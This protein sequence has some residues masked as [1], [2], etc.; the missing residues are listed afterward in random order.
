MINLNDLSKQMENDLNQRPFSTSDL[1]M[2]AEYFP[3]VDFKFRIILDTAEYQPPERDGNK[4]TIY[5]NGIMSIISSETEGINI[6]PL[7]YNALINTSVD[8]LIPMAQ[9]EDEDGASVLVEAVR[10]HIGTALQYGVSRDIEDEGG[11]KY[12]LGEFH[13]IGNT[14]MRAVRERVGDSMT[15]SLF[16]KYILIAAGVAS[17]EYQLYVVDPNDEEEPIVYSSLSLSRKTVIDYALAAEDANEGQTSARG[18][19]QNTVL[20][21][22]FSAPVRSANIDRLLADYMLRGTIEPIKIRL[23]IPNTNFPEGVILKMV[24]ESNAVGAEL[25]KAA[26]GAVTLVEYQEV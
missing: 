5:I 18:T 9:E 17:S 7:S 13:K 24:I 1:A 25:N 15:L 6:S 14:G 2:L 23:V 3:G 10:M 16:S 19:P 11:M 21:I 26:S 8:F 22:A 12:L 20:T 4:V